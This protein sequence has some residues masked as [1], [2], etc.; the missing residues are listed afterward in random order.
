MNKFIW[1]FDHYCCKNDLDFFLNEV[2][3]NKLIIYDLYVN[4]VIYFK[5]LPFNRRKVLNSHLDVL[6]IES[7]GFYTLFLRFFYYPR[8]W[9][10]FLVA[11]LT[12]VLLSNLVFEVKIYG[13]NYKYNQEILD[14]LNS[15]NIKKFS[16]ISDKE[17]KQIRNEY[18]KINSNK[19]E[20]F[21][22]KKNGSL[23]IVDYIKKSNKELITFDKKPLIAQKDGVIVYFDLISGNK[24]V[25]V[26]DFVTKGQI[27]VNNEIIKHDGNIEI[28]N[29]KGSV[30]AHTLQKILVMSNYTKDDLFNKC[31]AFFKLLSMSRIIIGREI[32]INEK[33]V[34]ENI[35]HFYQKEGKIYLEVSYTLLEDITVK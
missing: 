21:Q 11:I 34:K 31:L 19:Y 3:S 12:V 32:S 7:Q 25:K 14:Y 13:T 4:D 8:L 23:I 16:Y 30:Y 22:I 26:N 1:G 18:F 35:L 29:V 24:L 17:L 5:T 28:V 9:C 10:G 33:I 20:W 15:N 2:I 27:L 6:K